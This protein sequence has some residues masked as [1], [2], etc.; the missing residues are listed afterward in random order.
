MG[1]T[2]PEHRNRMTTEIHFRGELHTIP[3]GSALV[4]RVDHHITEKQGQ[5]IRAHCREVLGEQCRV[6]VIGPELTAVV[7]PSS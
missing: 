2:N 6:L 7:A 3:A 4:L 1:W 5:L